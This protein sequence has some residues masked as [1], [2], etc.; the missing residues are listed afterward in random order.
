[1][2]HPQ[3]QSEYM[4]NPCIIIQWICTP[5][6][7]PR[8]GAVSGPILP[9]EIE[10][11]YYFVQ[12]CP[13]PGGNG[14]PLPGRGLPLPIPPKTKKGGRRNSDP[15][16]AKHRPKHRQNPC[17]APRK[18]ATEWNG[19]GTE[20]RRADRNYQQGIGSNGRNWGT[21]AKKRSTVP[22]PFR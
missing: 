9:P 22:L 2:Q 1:M 17:A 21:V 5:G 16:Y 19:R 20:G 14:P 15:M 7:G 6:P 11:K 10:Q 3:A 18:T 4:H 13:T 12:F 8:L